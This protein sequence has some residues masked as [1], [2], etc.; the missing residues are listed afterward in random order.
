M[1]YIPSSLGTDQ[2]LV[3]LVAQDGAYARV[4][5]S[6]QQR[7]EAALRRASDFFAQVICR[8]ILR[9]LGVLLDKCESPPELK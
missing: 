5:P 1:L 4:D 3:S 7:T 2:H 8:F 6:E 9:D